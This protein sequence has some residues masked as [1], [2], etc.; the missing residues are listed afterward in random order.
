MLKKRKG[1]CWGLVAALMLSAGVSATFGM[2]SY[3]ANTTE[4]EDN[5]S[6][7]SATV[8]TPGTKISGVI[9]SR[10]D[11]DWYKF[12]LAEPGTISMVFSH[13]NSNDKEYDD[14]ET[15]LFR[16][17]GESVDYF[18]LGWD[19][20]PAAE[21]TTDSYNVPAGTYYIRVKTGVTITNDTHNLAGYG[22]KINYTAAG[23]NDE[24]ESNDTQ[25]TANEINVNQTYSARRS[26]SGDKDW[27]KFTLSE[28]GTISLVFSHVD[29]NNRE[30]AD[31][32]TAL[33][34]DGDQQPEYFDLDWD[35]GPAKE[36]E[37]DSYNVPA[38]TYYLRV[39]TLIGAAT[40]NPAKYG[41]KINYVSEEKFDF[42][43][44]GLSDKYVPTDYEDQSGSPMIMEGKDSSWND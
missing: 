15:Y 5:N 7:T 38:G 23:A 22:I 10:T 16:E 36:S 35:G 21:T 42:A 4:I 43:A 18:N 8:L 12:T 19:G 30:G 1:I 33:L 25:A 17:G 6:Q 24:K 27:F 37:T 9:S 28:P 34:G 14:W 31:W 20:G 3:A 41:I 26:L 40:H 2:N 11:L 32:Q 44:Y 29:S 39:K 13:E